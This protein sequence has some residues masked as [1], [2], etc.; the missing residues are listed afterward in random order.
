MKTSFNF[1]TSE[2]RI[3]SCSESPSKITKRSVDHKMCRAAAAKSCS[4]RILIFVLPLSFVLVSPPL[5]FSGGPPLNE[6]TPSSASDDPSPDFQVSALSHRGPSGT[7]EDTVLIVTCAACLSRY[8]AKTH[9]FECALVCRNS[10][11]VARLTSLYS[12]RSRNSQCSW[13][14]V[15]AKKKGV[16]FFR[17]D[18]T[19]GGV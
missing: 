2:S 17:G 18:G 8:D 12:F 4:I 10:K 3:W 5:A 15:S 14:G 16:S 19:S 1:W 11:W 7:I 9:I 6:H 13:T